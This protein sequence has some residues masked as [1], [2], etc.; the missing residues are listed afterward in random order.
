MIGIDS[1]VPINAA[2]V[3]VATRD[4]EGAMHI[5]E[6]HPPERSSMGREIRLD[7]VLVGKTPENEIVFV[8]EGMKPL[9]EECRIKVTCPTCAYQWRVG[10]QSSS[11][12]S[13]RAVRPPQPGDLCLC[14]NCGEELRFD[15][16]IQARLLTVYE[17]VFCVPPAMRNASM[18]IRIRGP[19]RRSGGQS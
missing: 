12:G 19:R 1:G 5:E 14:S 9:P 8:P 13:D 10:G 18:L 16:N 3:V 7:G 15:E 6:I 4:A 11:D 2:V 17:E